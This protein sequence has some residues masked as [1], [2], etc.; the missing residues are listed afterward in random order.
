MGKNRRRMRFKH[1]LKYVPK[2]VGIGFV[3]AVSL[4]LVYLWMG[5]KCSQYSEEIKRLEDQYTELEN[6]RM[7]EE[8]KWNGMKTAE[9]LDQLLVRNGLLMVYP[10]AAQIVR[11]SGSSR[12]TPATTALAQAQPVGVVSGAVARG[13][14]TR[15]A[16]G[17]MGR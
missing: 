16:S 9:Q 3:V 2:P 5:H 14:A 17:R 13:G 11:V 1:P 10:T 8:T 6:E 4:A 15:V 12:S 7:R